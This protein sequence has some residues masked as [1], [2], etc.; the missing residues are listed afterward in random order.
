MTGPQRLGFPVKVLG[1]PGL[2]ADDARKWQSGPHLRVSLGYLDQIFDYLAE[3]G[4]GMYRISSGIAPYLTHPD[5]PQFHNQ[6]EECAVELAAIGEKARRLDL[7]LSMHPA[8]FIVLNTPDEEVLRRSVADFVY[9]ADF[10][11]LLGLGPEAK[12]VTHVGGVYGDRAAAIDRWVARWEALPEKVRRRLVLENDERLFP[13]GDIVEIHRRTGVPL[14]FDILHHR[15]NNPDGLDDVEAL[16]ACLGSWP[17]GQRPKVHISSQRVEARSDPG[18]PAKVGE[19]ADWIEPDDLFVL[20][21]GT[22]DIPFD[23]MLEAKQKDL[24]LLRLRDAISAA[25]LS[26]RIW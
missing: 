12:I 18:K 1:R 8:Q 24:A 3:T 11:D 15:A 16:R 6:L 25:G 23:A 7:R 9:H 14:V 19:H 2:K 26:E 22:E 17:E 21:R 13:V 10:L 20:L 5:L 4:I